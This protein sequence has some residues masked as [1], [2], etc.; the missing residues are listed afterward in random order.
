MGKVPPTTSSDERVSFIKRYICR[1]RYLDEVVVVGGDCSCFIKV[2][3]GPLPPLLHRG[4]SYASSNG[5]ASR[6]IVKE[7]DVSLEHFYIIIIS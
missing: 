1:G 5:S 4:D 3:I 6:I 2:I 7:F